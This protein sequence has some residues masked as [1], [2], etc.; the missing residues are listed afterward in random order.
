MMTNPKTPCKNS[1]LFDKLNV[2]FGER[3]NLAR[4]KLISLMILALC[5]VQTASFY[6]LS[7]AFESGS[8]ALSCM[9]RIQRFMSSYMLDFDLIARL[10]LFG[11]YD[12]GLRLPH[13]VFLPIRPR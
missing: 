2:S 3:M 4:I 8:D 9:C 7:A 1:E 12:I 6:K 13:P 10:L 5:K 11:S